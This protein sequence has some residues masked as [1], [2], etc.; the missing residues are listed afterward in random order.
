MNEKDRGNLNSNDDVT[1]VGAKVRNLAG[2]GS[3]ETL[4][5]RV[6]AI[7]GTLQESPQLLRRLTFD[8]SY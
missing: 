4:L 7:T 1:V 5:M 2:R 6:A 8:L 3:R